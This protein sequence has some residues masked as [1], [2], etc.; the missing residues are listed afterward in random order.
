M[1]DAGFRLQFVQPVIAHPYNI[2]Y[3]NTPP[4]PRLNRII[5]SKIKIPDILLRRIYLAGLLP[6]IGDSLFAVAE[7]TE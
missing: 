5:D 3:P 7:K 6:G 2:L 1:R 4:T